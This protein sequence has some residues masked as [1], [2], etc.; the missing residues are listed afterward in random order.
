MAP[1]SN[2]NSEMP[3]IERLASEGTVFFRACKCTPPD[4]LT[5]SDPRTSDSQPSPIRATL[6]VLQP[7]VTVLYSTH[8]LPYQWQWHQ[9]PPT[10]LLI[11]AAQTSNPNELESHRDV[12]A[13]GVKVERGGAAVVDGGVTADVY[14]PPPPI[15]GMPSHHPLPRLPP[16]PL[17]RSRM[18][19]PC[20]GAPHCWVPW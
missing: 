9:M 1:Y 6:P 2:P 4:P 15:I 11:A 5:W 16:A 19:K 12:P 13:A 7:T 10:R 18:Q 14:F 20:H 17:S 8:P 3:A